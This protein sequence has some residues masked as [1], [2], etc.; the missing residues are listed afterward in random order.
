MNYKITIGKKVYE[1][2][3]EEPDPIEA[4]TQAMEEFLEDIKSHKKYFIPVVTLVQ[5]AENKDEG[6]EV[7]LLIANAGKYDIAEQMLEHVA[8]YSK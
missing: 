7:I 5:E 6:A 8:K 4:A 1:R 2:E 3:V